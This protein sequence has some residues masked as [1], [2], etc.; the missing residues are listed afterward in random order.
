M[1]LLRIKVVLAAVECDNEAVAPLEGA[2]E[3]ALAAGATLHIVHVAS[4]DSAQPDPAPFLRRLLD[5]AE[6][7]NDERTLHVLAG[8]PAHVIRSL[9]DRIRADVIVLGRHRKLPPDGQKIGSTALAVVTNSW[10][11]CLILPGA[12]R[13]PLERVVVPVDLSDTSRGAL[14]VAL[15][16]A[17]ALRGVGTSAASPTGGARL[18]ALRVATSGEASKDTSK[19]KQALD[20]ALARLRQEAGTWAGVAIDGTIAV[21][22]DVPAAIA[23]YAGEQ[24]ADLLVLGTRGLGLDAVG[25][26]GSV[27]LGIARRVASPILLVPPAVWSS[28]VGSMSNESERR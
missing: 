4:G 26:L 28:Y 21:S 16:W 3:L 19:Q 17:S 12:M 15:S 9:A 8:E 7:P 11:P 23:A 18:T 27:S 5:R 25:R 13:L 6:I 2:R 14:I 24:A 1:Q 20:D 22:D 10:A